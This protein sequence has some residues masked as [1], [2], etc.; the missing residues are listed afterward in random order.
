M[1]VRIY[2]VRGS[3]PT[4]GPTT[5]RY[6][7]NTVCTAVTLVDGT[8]VVL[9]AGTGMRALGN[10]LV[11]TAHAGEI[12][13]LLSH[14]HFDH[15]IGLPFFGPLFRAETRFAMH[16]VLLPATE[17]RARQSHVL[18]GIRTP[19]RIED[20]PA[21]VRFP[22][23]GDG[24]ANDFTVDRV[25]TVGSARVTRVLL[26][27]PGGA[28]GFRIDDADGSSL[29][30]LSDNELDPPSAP[31]T[32]PERLAAFAR[33]TGLLIC[34][35]QYLP[36]DMPGKRG[37]GHSTVPQVLALARMA[38][39]RATLLFHHD[40]DRTD[41]ALDRIAEQAGDFAREQLEGDVHVASEGITF[42]VDAA[43]TSGPR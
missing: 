16:P 31:T 7:G 27:H 13:L 32:K 1:R 25:W 24:P 43:R 26:N 19:L 10:D 36:E 4:P 12:H 9:D 35:S 29:T 40:P 20:L 5:V 3:V 38:A 33:G 11:A 15:I 17:R 8:C 18:D 39:A 22:D 6:G 30:Y 42:E 34:D 41:A 14:R 37:W 28:Q 23:H 21:R 2:G